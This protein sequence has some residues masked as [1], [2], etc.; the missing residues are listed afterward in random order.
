MQLAMQLASCREPVA[1]H[2]RAGIG[3]SSLV[4]AAV[5][6]LKGWI[7]ADALAAIATARR[8]PVPDTELQ[9]QWVLDFAS[10]VSGN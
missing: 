4:A 7:A 6:V 1:I 2:C 10:A 9:R 5:L 3:R 8:L